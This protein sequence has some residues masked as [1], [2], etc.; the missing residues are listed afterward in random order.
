MQ[1]TDHIHALKIHFQL[2]FSPEKKVDRSVYVYFIFGEKIHLVDCG[3]KGAE[4]QIFDYLEAN[5]RKK[6]DIATLMISHVHPDH[7]GSAVSM[8]S[9]TA[10]KIAVHEDDRA[11]LEDIKKHYQ[12]R[13]IPGFQFLV[14]GPVAPDTILADGDRLE[15]EPGLGLQV[16]HTPGHSA[17]S[18]SFYLESDQALITGDALPLPGD[19]PLYDDIAQSLDS[20]RKLQQLPNVRSLFSSWEDP[21]TDENRIPERM[22]A[23]LQLLYKIHRSVCAHLK[24]DQTDMALCQEVVTALSLPEIAVNPVMAKALSSSRAHCKDSNFIK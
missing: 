23:S 9:K 8:K 13:P 21:I 18:V 17:G 5:G 24:E 4:Q 20:V 14:E 19:L 2:V 22:E 7:I 3:V 1:I 16:I 11:W 10:C 15:L 12:A 6:E